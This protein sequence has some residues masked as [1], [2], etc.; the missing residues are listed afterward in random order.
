MT[1]PS[2]SWQT[3]RVF[4]T[5]RKLDATPHSG[6]IEFTFSTR[7]VSNT[8]DVIFPAGSVLS[9]PL[10]GSGHVEIQIPAVDDPDNFP[11]NWSVKVTERLA[12]GG[13]LTY[14][15]QPTLAMVAGGLNLRSLVLDSTNSTPAPA[16]TKGV[17]GGLA[18]LNANGDVVNAAGD[19]VVVASGTPTDGQILAWSSTL[20][21]NAYVNPSGPAELA[22][23]ENATKVPQACAANAGITLTGSI[24]VPAS[25]R[26]VYLRCG[27][28]WKLTASGVG[29][30]AIQWTETT[31]GSN[32]VP[33][34]SFIPILGE[35]VNTQSGLRSAESTFR[36]G[37]VA[38]P[39]IFHLSIF[40]IV[41]SGAPAI[42]VFNGALTSGNGPT[43]PS[44]LLAEA[45]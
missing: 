15:I 33:M 25:T 16:L 40:V 26:P 42:S 43:H 44:W 7:V 32:A 37:P 18:A 31:S 35:T 6:T 2:P 20:G 30:I 39:R 12:A 21:A 8:D 11:A 1:A 3:I 41:D 29:N 24:V 34:L 28:D 17:P 10:D 27:F 9:V 5:F 14:Y 36:L 23:I 45:K 13:G 22:Y 38:S 19:T 4:G